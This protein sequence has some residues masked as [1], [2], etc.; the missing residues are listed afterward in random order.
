M[1]RFEAKL[2]SIEEE[3]GAL[4]LAF[5]RND[6]EEYVI[7]SRGI[8]YDDQDQA[9]GHD[10]AH[11]EINDQFYRGYGVIENVEFAGDVLRLTFDTTRLGLGAEHSPMEIKG[12][13][14]TAKRYEI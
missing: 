2:V 5:G 14:V 9:L 7:L 3:D 11:L 1:K 10:V 6:G 12:A 8:S 4:F 13:E